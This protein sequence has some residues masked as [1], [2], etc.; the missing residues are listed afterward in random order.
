MSRTWFVF[1]A[2]AFWRV[3]RIAA[4]RPSRWRL[5]RS[6]PGF[7][8]ITPA[9]SGA[10]ARARRRN[11]AS[12]IAASSPSSISARMGPT[13]TA[14]SSIP[15][16][17]GRSHVLWRRIL[18]RRGGPRRRPT[19][20]SFTLVEM[21]I[22]RV[23]PR[24]ASTT[25][26]PMMTAGLGPLRKSSGRRSRTR[27]RPGIGCLIRTSIL[28]ACV[29]ASACMSS[30]EDRACTDPKACAGGFS[31]LS[32]GYGASGATAW[33]SAAFWRY[34]GS[35]PDHPEPPLEECLLDER[36]GSEVFASLDLPPLDAGET[37]SVVGPMG[38]ME[39][40]KFHR[41]ESF[42]YAAAV[43][44]TGS[45]FVP[46]SAAY[47]LTGSGGELGSFSFPFST[48]APIDL[49]EP[50][51]ALLGS[52]SIPTGENLE[53]RWNGT[54]E[55]PIEVSFFREACSSCA[56][57]FVTCRF[58]DDGDAV[59][60]ADQITWVRSRA[61]G[62]DHLRIR[63]RLETLQMQSTLV[64]PFRAQAQVV[65]FFDPPE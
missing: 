34:G 43:S 12:R 47:V 56:T 44:S 60:T 19:A 26:P 24:R 22:Q 55:Q 41:P 8:G 64:A 37:V 45:F 62:L 27:R 57:P 49:I 23:A 58:E 61:S 14:D 17:R 25:G 59:L 35:W 39:L 21:T 9:T 15:R 10:P 33:A 7:R 11:A 40:V 36:T 38:T 52:L 42:F 32:L 6:A 29:A 54:A 31:S 51:P 18:R 30:G 65:Y 2:A 5:A 20:T 13:G 1:A 28:V 63:R 4:N 53:I 3:V 16:P 48:P 50:D 46:S